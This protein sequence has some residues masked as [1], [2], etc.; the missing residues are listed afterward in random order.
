[1]I[2]GVLR[3]A[4]A[5]V[6]SVEVTNGGVAAA[7]LTNWCFVVDRVMMREWLDDRL[8]GTFLGRSPFFVIYGH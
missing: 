8:D 7:V 5:I 2:N 3:N 6:D 4:G 1:M